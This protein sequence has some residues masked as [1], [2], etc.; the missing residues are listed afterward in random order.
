MP[1]DLADFER[2]SV[3]KTYLRMGRNQMLIAKLLQTNMETAFTQRE[4]KE[5]CDIEFDAAVN[6][7][8]HSL[9]IKGF[10]VSKKIEHT[11]YWR[12]TDGLLEVDFSNTNG[13]GQ[14]AADVED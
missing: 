14:K 6:T 8:L 7:A 12:G 11:L 10:A 5:K 13:N 3:N 9:K 4:I 1:L 2:L